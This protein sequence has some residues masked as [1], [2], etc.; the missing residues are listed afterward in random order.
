MQILSAKAFSH[1]SSL[2]FHFVVLC[3]QLADVLESRDIILEFALQI[4]LLSLYSETVSV[5]DVVVVVVAAA[6][7][8]NK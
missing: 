7:P 3:S 5:F 2:W 8:R 6:V 1:L 4:I